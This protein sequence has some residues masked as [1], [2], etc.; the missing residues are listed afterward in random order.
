MTAVLALNRHFNK[1]WRVNLWTQIPL[2]VKNAVMQLFLFFS[3]VIRSLFE[4]VVAGSVFITLL[5]Q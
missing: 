3:S 2:L 4:A 5:I 1:K